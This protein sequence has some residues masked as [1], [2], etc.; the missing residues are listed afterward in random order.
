MTAYLPIAGFGIATL[1]FLGLVV[2]M[3][4]AWQGS[5]EGTL[6]ILASALSMVWA[7][8]SAY[9]MWLGVPVSISL[10][11]S[12]VL[13]DT[14]WL[15]FLLLALSRILHQDTVR[16]FLKLSIF[17]VVAIG[18]VLLLFN[19]AD[20]VHSTIPAEI[21][22]NIRVILFLAFC[23]VGMVVTEQIYRNTPLSSRWSIKYIC[24]GL[25]GLF[26]YDFYLYADSLLSKSFDVNIWGAR[27]YINAMIVP[28]IAVAVARNPQ[29]SLD[30]YV[31]RKFVFHGASIIGAGIY[32]IAMVTGGYYIKHFGGDW[33]TLAQLTFLFGALILLLALFISGQMRARLKVFLSKHFF[34]YRYDYR[35]EWLR[36]INALSDAQLGKNINKKILE[37]MMQI[38]ESP[39]GIIWL[40]QKDGGYKIQESKSLPKS[41][42]MDIGENRSIISF[43]KERRWI[44][45]LSEFKADKK[46]YPNMILPKWLEGIENAWLIV[47]LFSKVAM[48]IKD[49]DHDGETENKNADEDLM[50]FVVLARSNVLMNI[51]WEARDLLLT[52]GSQCASYIALEEV[53]ERLMEARQFD[54]FNRLSAYVVHD[55]KNIIAQLA[56]VAK[57]SEKHRYN[58]EFIDDS[59]VTIVNATSKMERLL[60]L[61][62]KGRLDVK[63]KQ[64]QIDLNNILMMVVKNR[65]GILPLPVFEGLDSPL[66]VTANEERLVT[67]IGHLIQNAQEA[68]EEDGSVFIRLVEKGEWA[69]IEIEDTGCGMDDKFVRNS[70]FRPFRTTKGNA[71]MGIGVYESREII[72]S[73]GG[74]MQVSSTPGIGTKFSLF[75][76]VK[77]VNDQE[78]VRIQQLI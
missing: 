72:V 51:N 44:I 32:F 36:L 9:Q 53:N 71:G 31:S 5:R 2:L 45:D 23:L 38:V 46:N 10:V 42:N 60:A 29:W 22:F 75:L 68:T 15:L 48:E 49:K 74:R 35:E 26:A 19:Y 70:L 61:L 3:L 17:F 57:N 7:G 62:R 37:V 63:D 18:S 52:I 28:L 54:V 76:P 43:M 30:I 40:R 58:Q 4:T 33:A 69:V 56:L 12:E 13:R 41:V 67:V 25:G 65:R 24:I 73:L 39:G 55:L 78:P 66:F 34:N 8:L 27:G 1:A 21:S 11:T 6:L 64:Q 16:S 50:G 77:R 59:F 47:P 14:A 20:F